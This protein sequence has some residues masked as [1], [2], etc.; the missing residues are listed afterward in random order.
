MAAT[1]FRSWIPALVLAAAASPLIAAPADAVRSR[2]ASYRELGAAYKSVND[3]LRGGE[4]QA[5]LLAQS[6]K[7]IRN[8]AR[9][10]YG[11]FPAGSGPKAGVKTA[12]KAEIWSNPAKFKAAQDA[13]AAAAERFQ[14]T[15]AGRDP[16]AIRSEARKLGAACKGCHDSFRV[17]ED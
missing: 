2:I 10:Q 11:W 9:G 13:F 3:S 1:A 17:E 5:V 14:K 15:V 7:Q 12:A 6:A 16:S 4:V 8:A